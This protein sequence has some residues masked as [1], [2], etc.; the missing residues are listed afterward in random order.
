MKKYSF[1][2]L[3]WDKKNKLLLAGVVVL[4]WLVYTFAISNTLEARIV[5]VQQQARLDSAQG[6]P[7]QLL[8]LETE[9]AKFASLTGEQNDTVRDMHEHV[10]NF[11][12][13]YC[14]E[15]TLE[16]REFNRPVRYRQQEWTVETHPFIVEGS[17]IEIVQ[18]LHALELSGNG[19]VVSAD[20]HTKTDTK[21]KVKSLLA[22]IYIQNITTEAS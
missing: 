9:L 16:L 13:V 8:Q 1:T 22:T 20:L 3:T 5:C 18:L 10:L 15:H 14:N 6:A 4:L 19:R 21:T 12:T 7:D 17:Y 11:V 2:N